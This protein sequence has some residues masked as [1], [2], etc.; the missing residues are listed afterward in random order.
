MV[1]E[2]QIAETPTVMQPTVTSWAAVA[3]LGLYLALV[4]ENDIRVVGP[5]LV[6]LV[7]LTLVVISCLRVCN[8]KL[9]L[10]TFICLMLCIG[11][12]E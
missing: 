5:V 2:I 4:F 10:N 3:K 1:G 11:C 8:E 6:L 7:L 9:R 12:A